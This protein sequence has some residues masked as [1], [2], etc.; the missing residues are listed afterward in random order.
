[1]KYYVLYY[2]AKD[3]YWN[4]DAPGWTSKDNA[5]VYSQAEKDRNLLQGKWIEVEAPAATS[6]PRGLARLDAAGLAELRAIIL[7]VI[8]DGD[9][10][11]RLPWALDPTFKDL[12]DFANTQRLDFCDAIQ[13]A[14]V[15]AA[16]P[17]TTATVPT[18][19][20]GPGTVSR[21]EDIQP[22]QVRLLT[23]AVTAKGERP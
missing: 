13:A 4:K 5:T 12:Q 7:T 6:E 15:K 18:Y 1:M 10:K 16:A 17:A 23:E 20:T 3:R 11:T 19:A 14:I 8:D 22:E 21:G 9:P 2:H